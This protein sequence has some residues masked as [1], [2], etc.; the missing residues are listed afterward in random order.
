MDV[1]VQ[2]EGKHQSK[3]P[4]LLEPDPKLESTGIQ[5]DEAYICP[6]ED[7]V[8]VLRLPNPSN[9][10]NRVEQRSLLGVVESASLVD[11]DDCVEQSSPEPHLVAECPEVRQVGAGAE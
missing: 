6:G 2:L 3:A 1:K 11:E 10:T 8:A 7:G 4:V 9:F 5:L